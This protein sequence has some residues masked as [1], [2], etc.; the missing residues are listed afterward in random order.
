MDKAYLRY[1]M[2]TQGV[3]KED[4]IKT[5]DWGTSTY[6]RKVYGDADWRLAEMRILV[7]LLE[8]TQDE[9]MLIFFS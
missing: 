8:L 6:Q 2:E 5:M 9:I 1:K 4:L 3:S 7:G